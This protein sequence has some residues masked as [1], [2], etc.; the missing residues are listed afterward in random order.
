MSLNDS[1]STLSAEDRGILRKLAHAS[2][3][4]GLTGGELT[5]EVSDYSAALQALRASFVTVHVRNELHGCM[6]SLE[7]E[8]PLVVDVV[9]NAYAAAFRDPRFSALSPREYEYL[10]VHISLL[11]IPEPMEFE[12]EEDLLRQLRPGV[13]GLVLIEGHRRGTFLPAVWETLAD[14]REFLRHLKHKA[15]L[16]Q[17]YWSESIKIQR[18]TAESIP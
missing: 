3:E 5:V 11:S 13:D 8:R 1:A 6:G 14:S 2:I 16:P 15:G 10:D 17:D 12:S 18:Y 4:E 9:K 7:P